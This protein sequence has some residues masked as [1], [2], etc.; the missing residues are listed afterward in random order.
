MHP[1]CGMSERS[2]PA[3]VVAVLRTAASFAMVYG[4]PKQGA[5]QAH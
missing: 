1:I 3:Y 2:A 5:A 4:L